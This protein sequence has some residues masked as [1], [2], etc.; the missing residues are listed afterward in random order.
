M[1]GRS[2]LEQ[3]QEFMLGAV[4][5]S[6]PSIC[7]GPDDEVERSKPEVQ[8]SGHKGGM[9]SPINERA[10]NAAIAKIRE[11]RTD[12]SCVEGPELI[13]SHFAAS[14]NEF[15]VRAAC[16]M[17]THRNIVGLIGQDQT[18]LVLGHQKRK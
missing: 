10:K 18:G 14:H 6:H 16:D 3:R 17:T 13:L 4:K 5:A 9:T 8:G 1:R 12:P 11:R 2:F 15:P 7:L